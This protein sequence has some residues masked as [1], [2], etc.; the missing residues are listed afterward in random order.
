V[1]GKEEGDKAYKSSNT[2]WRKG[3]RET[4]KK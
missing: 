2:E 3:R 1:S 4:G